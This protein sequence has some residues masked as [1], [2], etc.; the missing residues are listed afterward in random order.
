MATSCS[1]SHARKHLQL[2]LHSVDLASFPF[3]QSPVL[4]FVLDLYCTSFPG[5]EELPNFKLQRKK[6]R[7]QIEK[8]KRGEKCGNLLLWGD[9]FYRIENISLHLGARRKNTSSKEEKEDNTF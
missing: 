5:T 7:G 9:H 1:T 4:P 3:I 6:F 2:L 8:R